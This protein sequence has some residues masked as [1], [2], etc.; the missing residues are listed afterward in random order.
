MT[1]Y[2]KAIEDALAAGPTPG[3]W[4]DDR[5]EKAVYPWTDVK[6]PDHPGRGVVAH[7]RLS[8]VASFS[9]TIG[10]AEQEWV[11]AAYIAACH[12][13]ALRTLLTR[14]REAE[15]D[16]ARSREALEEIAR[17]DMTTRGFQMLAENAL[18]AMKE[19]T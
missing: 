17:A 5:H 1:D 16:A 12:P 8:E 13:E 7:V 3:P 19:S 4:I 14:L 11:N 15:A 2:I 9:C 10:K 6:A 18:D